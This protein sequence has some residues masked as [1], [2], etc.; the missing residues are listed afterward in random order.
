MDILRAAFGQMKKFS[1]D[2][3]CIL[4]ILRKIEME[5]N[6]FPINDLLELAD[7]IAKLENDRQAIMEVFATEKS[8]SGTETTSL[9]NATSQLKVSFLREYVQSNQNNKNR[10]T[11]L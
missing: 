7:Q 6:D 9:S 8:S 4:E 11:F 1:E 2:A 3:S 10:K 5:E